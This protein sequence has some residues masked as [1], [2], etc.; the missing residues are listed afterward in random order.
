ME[1]VAIDIMGPWPETPRKNLYVLVIQDYFSKWVAAW[2]L[3]NHRAA[4]VAQTLVRDYFSL[5]GAPLRLHT[6]Q[7]QEFNSKLMS[8]LYRLWEISKSRT[9]PYAPWSD[10]MVERCNR[11][12]LA[13]V[14]HYVNENRND[15]DLHLWAVIMAYNFTRHSSTGQTPF[16]LFHSR[17][18][19][20]V[21][22]ADLMFGHALPDRPVVCPTEFV[23]LQRQAII[24]AFCL[25][26]NKLKV[27]ASSQARLYNQGG[28]KMRDYVVGDR[29]WRFYP[30]KAN[31]KLGK[32]WTGPW[33]VERV[34]SKW[35]VQIGKPESTSTKVHASC[36][37]PVV[38]IP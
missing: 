26:R 5:Y 11:S 8:A 2:P 24:K 14:K 4:T 6:D 9:T 15:W 32:S 7:G 29:V 35:L 31:L 27:S 10:G 3:P 22:P 37:K 21:I 28:L 1:R 34:M 25:A 18:E 16:L 23:E 17:C 12:I 30:P 19:E 20:P 33:T 38:S 13:M 36:L